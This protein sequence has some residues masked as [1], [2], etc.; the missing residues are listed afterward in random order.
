MPH[1]YLSL[2]LSIYIYICIHIHIHIYI[3]IYTHTYTHTQLYY[4]ISLSMYIYIYIYVYIHIYIYIYVYPCLAPHMTKLAA[5]RPGPAPKTS[6]QQYISH[7]VGFHNFN[8]RIFNLRVSIRTNWLW[9]SFWHDVGFQCASVSARKNTMK[10][11]KST[12]Q[13]HCKDNNKHT[14]GSG[15]GTQRGISK[16]WQTTWGMI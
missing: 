14:H 10:L 4:I 16:T 11:W 6:K 15:W 5:V 8:L 2:S 13:P 7:T 1:I 9:M 3:Y 12:V